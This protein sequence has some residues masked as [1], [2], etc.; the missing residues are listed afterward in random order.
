MRSLPD[1]LVGWEG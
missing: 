1:P